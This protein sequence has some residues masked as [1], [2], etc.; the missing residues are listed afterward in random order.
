[1]GRLEH[2]ADRAWLAELPARATLKLRE[3]FLPLGRGVM[4][5]CGMGQGAYGSLGVWVL[6]PGMGLGCHGGM[7]PGYPLRYGFGPNALTLTSPCQ[8]ND[9]FW[10]RH[11]CY[12]SGREGMD[13]D[14]LGTAKNGVR[15]RPCGFPSPKSVYDLVPFAAVEER[16]EGQQPF[17]PLLGLASTYLEVTI[18]LRWTPSKNDARK[19]VTGERMR[20]WDSTRQRLLVALAMHSRL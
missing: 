9:V 1:M 2:S 18:G 19:L 13:S 6:S 3:L 16:P 11:R 7:G 10:A 15:G 20:T 5:G 8:K 4:A 12:E 17:L 14:D